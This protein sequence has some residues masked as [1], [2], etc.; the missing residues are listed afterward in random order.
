M[1]RAIY[2]SNKI[3]NA[4]L[5]L[6]ETTKICTHIFA[7]QD[8]IAED[9]IPQS[10]EYCAQVKLLLK[11]GVEN[12]GLKDVVRARREVIQHAKAMKFLFHRLVTCERPLSELLFC[13]THKILCEG[14]TLENGDDD[15]NYAG[16]YRNTTVAAGSTIFT[17]PSNV[18]AEMK[19][20]VA[21]FDDD[22]QAMY[23][24]KI[25]DPCYLAADICQDFVMVHPFKDGNGRM[26]RL[27]ANALL[28][29]YSGWVV[30][31]GETEEDRKAY[32]RIAVRAGDPEMEEEAK[33]ELAWFI[34]GKVE[35]AGALRGKLSICSGT[36]GF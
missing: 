25:I 5:N 1:T 19:K 18:P 16:V 7:G 15:E 17:A 8:V 36:E 27:I 21:G 35:N 2:G 11:R 31:I 33:K 32:L 34:R 12:P 23:R 22:I 6:S 29:R 30:A 14:V 28:L 26:C 13:E 3:E 24:G 10:P 20:L 9:I 4:G